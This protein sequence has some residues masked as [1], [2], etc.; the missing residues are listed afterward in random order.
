MKGDYGLWTRG[1]SAEGR[2]HLSMKTVEERLNAKMKNIK[3][4]EINNRPKFPQNY[5]TSSIKWVS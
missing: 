3:S 1:Q 4:V 2:K 5:D